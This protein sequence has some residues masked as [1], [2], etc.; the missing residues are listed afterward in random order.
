MQA[1]LYTLVP[2]VAVIAGAAY[3]S[4]RRPGP[5]FTAGVQHL[6]AGVVF[7]AAAGE[8]LPALKH[9][10]S[11]VAVLLGGALGVVLMLA[12]KRIGGTIYKR[13]RIY[14]RNIRS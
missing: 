4:W 7:A 10:V 8:I 2:L 3:A 6:A 12:I 1:L 5:A 14:E 13:H 11:P 9:T